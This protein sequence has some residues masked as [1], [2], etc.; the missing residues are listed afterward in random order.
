MEMPQRC[1]W[2][3]GQTSCVPSTWPSETRDWTY[4][5]KQSTQ[6]SCAHAESRTASA[7]ELSHRQ[8][9]AAS[10]RA[11]VL[12]GRVFARGRGVTRGGA[13]AHRADDVLGGPLPCAN[14]AGRRCI[15][16]RLAI[17]LGG[18][19]G[20]HRGRES[21]ETGRHGTCGWVGAGQGV[22]GIAG[23]EEALARRE[24]GRASRRQRPPPLA[25]RLGLQH[26]QPRPTSL[27]VGNRQVGRTAPLPSHPKAR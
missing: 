3:A 26:E 16:W 5:E 4:C 10:A 9:C 8:I 20:S 7:G 17:M 12:G 11:H 27:L 19:G 2:T 1:G 14:G 24:E 23:A 25:P 18:G 6:N 21:R 22:V 15:R 13:A